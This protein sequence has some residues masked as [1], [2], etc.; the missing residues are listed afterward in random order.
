MILRFKIH[1]FRLCFKQYKTHAYIFLSLIGIFYARIM[2]FLNM[3]NNSSHHIS[4]FCNFFFINY[5]TRYSILSLKSNVYRHFNITALN[6][7]ILLFQTVLRP[8]D[9]FIR[10]IYSYL[11][12]DY[13][14]DIHDKSTCKGKWKDTI[15]RWFV[16]FF[17]V[18]LFG[19]HAKP[20]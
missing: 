14:S 1:F 13:I 12:P 16:C 7:Y 6:F 2:M 3:L 20:H 8:T 5:S 11:P 17:A 10:S 9:I 15:S 19:W 18:P 4:I